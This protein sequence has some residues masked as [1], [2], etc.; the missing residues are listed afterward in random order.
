MGHFYA[1]DVYKGNRK[2]IFDDLK[3]FNFDASQPF[4]QTYEMSKWK[5]GKDLTSMDGLLTAF[6]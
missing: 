1:Y 3:S 2:L 6:K 5:T 4:Q